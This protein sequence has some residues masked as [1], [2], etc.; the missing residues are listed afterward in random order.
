[1]LTLSEGFIMARRNRR[2]QIIQLEK[3]PTFKPKNQI[4]IRPRTE[5]Q[6]NAMEAW[7]DG[8]NLS[9]SGYAGTGKTFVALHLALRAVENYG[10]QEQVIIVRST[11]P[12]RE[13][14]FLPGTTEEKIEVYEQ[15]YYA[16]CHELT[17]N[18]NAYHELKKQ[19]LL[20]FI[21]TSFIR[22]CT[23]NDKVV[24]VDEMQNMNYHEL[25]SVITRLGT[26]S[27]LILCGDYRQ[28]DF[29]RER[30]K[31]GMLNI[32]KILSEISE[33]EMIEFSKDDILRSS[34]VK[35]YI[36]MKEELKLVA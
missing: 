23:L 22:G 14:G 12:T 28:S 5:R 20:D 19:G 9:L 30:E 1:M 33:F 34:L 35:K 16:L 18:Y 7:N 21:S 3:V 29:T 4:N 24:I 27:R 13:M 17:G 11:V 2:S 8:K 25:D 31:E 15:P 10:E 26:N 32:L 36:I 6:T